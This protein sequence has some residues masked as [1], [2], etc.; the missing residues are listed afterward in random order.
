MPLINYE[1]NFFVT[2]SANCFLV[3]GTAANQVLTFA[4]TDT[5]LYVLIVPLSTQ[6]NAKLLQQ[7][8]SGFKHLINW[9]KYRS[10]ATIHR[11]N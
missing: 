6:R 4:V 2:W 8:K 10:K 7:F 1:I 5:K 9:N 11:K 3:A